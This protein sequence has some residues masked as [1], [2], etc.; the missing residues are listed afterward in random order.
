M[1]YQL[2]VFAIPL[3]CSLGETLEHRRGAQQC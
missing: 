3:C 2:T 1:T